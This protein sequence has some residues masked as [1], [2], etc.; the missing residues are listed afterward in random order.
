MVFRDSF[1]TANITFN[2][3]TV[4]PLNRP[5]KPELPAIHSSANKWR[6]DPINRQ[7]LVTCF[8]VALLLAKET[9]FH[10]RLEQAKT[11]GGHV[12]WNYVPFIGN[13]WTYVAAKF[14]EATVPIK[15]CGKYG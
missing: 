6:C 5:G 7:K 15:G 12:G 3:S 4:E 9:Q 13:A 10:S 11:C 14:A 8:W 2:L 1:F